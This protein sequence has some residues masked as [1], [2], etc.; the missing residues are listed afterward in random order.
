MKKIVLTVL[1]GVLCLSMCSCGSINKELID[2]VK[3]SVE[4]SEQKSTE[5]ETDEVQATET[6]S[7]SSKSA[8]AVGEA[9]ET[10]NV[11]VTMKGITENNGSEYNKPADGNVFVLCEFD[12]ANNSDADINISSMLNFEGYCD[13]YKCDFSFSALIEKGDKNQLD[14]KVAA[15]KKMNGVVGYEVPA[16][17]K[18][19]EIHFNP[20]LIGGGD[21]IIF[22]AAKN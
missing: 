12:I 11:V 9:A 16:E 20:T 13:D 17:W 4:D 2:K 1:A 22:K 6:V 19:M 8:F 5:N 3:Q 10:D 18:E 7:K 14:G 15:G 21:D